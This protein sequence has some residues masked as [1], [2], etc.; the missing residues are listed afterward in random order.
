MHFWDWKSGY[1]FQTHQTLAQ[2]GSLATE[3]GFFASTFD[4]TGSRLITGEADK[5]IK[6]WKEDEA[7]TEQSHPITNYIPKLGK[8]YGL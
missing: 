2:S 7:A 5:S 1:N 3:A 8:L 6:I 4:R